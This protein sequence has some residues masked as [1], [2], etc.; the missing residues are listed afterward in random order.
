MGGEEGGE[1]VEECG[2]EGGAVGEERG[3]GGVRG[4]V[5]AEDDYLGG[6]GVGIDVGGR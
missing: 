5:A 4:G 1:G 6:R 3:V 2:G